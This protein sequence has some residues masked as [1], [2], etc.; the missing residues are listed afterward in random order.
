MLLS[1]YGSEVLVLEFP[2]SFLSS[3][4]FCT[5]YSSLSKTFE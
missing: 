2:G 5:K 4:A 3:A 1:R